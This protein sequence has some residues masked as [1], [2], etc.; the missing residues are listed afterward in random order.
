MKFQR[1]FTLLLLM[2]VSLALSG[3]DLLDS[4]PLPTDA[5][6][7]NAENDW[8]TFVRTA[9]PQVK[10]GAVFSLHVEV[11]AKADLELLAVSETVPEGFTVTSG[12]TTLFLTNVAEGE[13]I[14]LDYSLKA[15]SKKGS[16]PL[17][18]FAR[19]KPTD[20]DSVQLELISPLQVR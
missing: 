19:A 18:G 15:G 13:I 4:K 6:T 2:V 3:C 14:E 12:T 1:K 9:L 8:V 17:S 7:L 10:K 20:E 16:F 11:V 5:E